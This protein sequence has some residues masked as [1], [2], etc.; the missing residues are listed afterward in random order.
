MPSQYSLPLAASGT[1][2]GVKIGY[3]ASGANIPLKLSSEKG[4]VTLTG[5]AIK[6]AVDDAGDLSWAASSYTFKDST[7]GE[8]LKLDG[9]LIYQNS[10]S[11]TKMVVS[12]TGNMGIAGYLY[13]Y[14]NTSKR[15]P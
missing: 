4:Y 7:S 1:R 5:A 12:N 8:S 6:K 2:G 9:S 15:A 14:D 11:A 3:S 13:Q 10:S